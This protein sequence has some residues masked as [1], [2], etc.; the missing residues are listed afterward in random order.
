MILLLGATGYI[1][2]AFA[3]ELRRR[4]QLF[5]PLTRKALDYT[6][7]DFLFDY[8]RKIK[9]EFLINAAGYTGRPNVDGCETARRDAVQA[10]TLFPQMVARVCFMTN[11]PWGHVSSGC[12]YSGAKVVHDGRVRVEKDLARPRLRRLF[13]EHPER[14]RGFTETD[15]PNFSFRSPPCSFY[16]GTKALAEEVIAKT[17]NSY[18]WRLRIPFDEFDHPRNFLTKL[19]R[20][21]KVYDNV[22]SL[23]HRGDFVR[24]C[25]DLWERRAPFG[26]YNI[27]NSGAVAT[28]LVVQL[29]DKILKPSRSFCFWKNDREFYALAAKAPRSNCILDVSKLLTTGVRMRQVT[30]ALQDALERWQP[31]A[32][33]LEILSTIPESVS[34]VPFN[35]VHLHE[36]KSPPLRPTPFA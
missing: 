24:A 12:I 7:F 9:P 26:T 1:G 35:L 31:S 17:G 18:L 15:E 3:D 19:Q 21:S 25:L 10:N 2:Q 29:I 30:D 33:N 23:S 32:N 4:G 34:E 16:S 20:Y 22:N 11:T 5:V 28:R 8:I 36:T 13:D 6:N 14:F 27:T